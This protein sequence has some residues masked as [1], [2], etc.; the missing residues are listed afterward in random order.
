LSCG[1]SRI[2]MSSTEEWK[3]GFLGQPDPP[4]L[5][6]LQELVVEAPKRQ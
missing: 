1:K 2:A 4:T 6:T 5:H 3:V